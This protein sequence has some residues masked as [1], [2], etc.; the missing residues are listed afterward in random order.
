MGDIDAVLFDMDGTLVGS[1]AAV[2]LA[3][4]QWAA[5][6]DLPP[7]PVLAAAY[8]RPISA[9]IRHLAP[10]LDD[11]AVR[12]EVDRQNDRE[13]ADAD[14]TKPL[15]GAYELLAELDPARDTVGG[16]DQRWTA[17][18][19]GP[20]TGDWHHPTDPGDGRRRTCRKAR[21]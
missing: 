10:W 8:G 12:L 21:S 18:R 7:E 4:R 6:H 15:P 3:W 9:T 13:V 11:D 5:D 19:G 2:E 17:A 14:G 1:D 20:V 16:R